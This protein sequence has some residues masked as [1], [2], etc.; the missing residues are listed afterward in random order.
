M[1]IVEDFKDIADRLNDIQHP[2]RL[3]SNMTATE[4]Q[5]RIDS[6]AF[7]VHGSVV[8]IVNQAYQRLNEMFPTPDE[9]L[10]LINEYDAL[11]IKRE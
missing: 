1:P 2:K 10:D 3:V 6:Y 7:P 5:E 9:A 8:D 4:L 11:G